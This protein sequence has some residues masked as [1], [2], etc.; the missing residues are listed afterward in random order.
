MKK[1]HFR[2]QPLYFQFFLSLTWLFGMLFGFLFA[3]I[4][5]KNQQNF[6]V[7]SLSSDVSVVAMLLSATVPYVLS[8]VILHFG[9]SYYLL[10]IV[11]IKSFFFFYSSFCILSV[12]SDAGWLAR[13]LLMF[14]SSANAVILLWFWVANI[15]RKQIFLRHFFVCITI[16]MT[17]CLIDFCIVPKILS[18][19]VTM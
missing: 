17:A 18:R 14:S 12:Y 11:F 19:I 1:L 8:A 3:V 10:P 16:C 7:F 4:A 9:N 15:H 13:V 2:N 6:Y 5:C